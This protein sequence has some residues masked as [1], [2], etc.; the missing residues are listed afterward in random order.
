MKPQ[1]SG[2]GSE[3]KMNEKIT[4]TCK[5]QRDEKPVFECGQQGK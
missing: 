1:W 2:I 3:D 5:Q 4:S